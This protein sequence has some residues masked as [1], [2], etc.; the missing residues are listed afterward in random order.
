MIQVVYYS[1]Q[2]WK[3]IEGNPSLIMKNKRENSAK[4]A[5]N[6]KFCVVKIIPFLIAIF[7]QFISIESP[8]LARKTIVLVFQSQWP[9]KLKNKTKIFFQLFKQTADGY[10]H[11]KSMKNI[12]HQIISKNLYN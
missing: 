5:G 7:L 1:S 11:M 10:F 2:V 6:F 4:K 8:T 9:L 12:F 3:Y